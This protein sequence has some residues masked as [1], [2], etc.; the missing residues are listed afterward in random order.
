MTEKEGQ[1]RF[2]YFTDKYQE[3]WDFYNNILGFKLE[4]SWDRHENDKGAVFKAGAGLIE[5]LHHPSNLEQKISG[6]D[7]RTPQGVFMVIQDWNVDDLYEKIKAKG[8]PFK[9]EIVDQD[10]GH[11]SFS[12]FEPNGLVLFFFEERFDTNQ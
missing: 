6:L 11:R 10:W 8:I 9:Q 3:T 12:I 5:I 4:H 2:A 1:F 7:F